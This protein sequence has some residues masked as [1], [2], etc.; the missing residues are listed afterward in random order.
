MVGV[1][2]SG[3]FALAEP[4]DL[5]VEDHSSGADLLLIYATGLVGFPP[6]GAVIASLAARIE[7]HGRSP[8]MVQIAVR[9]HNEQLLRHAANT[10]KCQQ[11]MT[12]VMQHS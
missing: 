6:V 11:R 5:R 1:L 3:S 12:Q 10:L 7:C 4:S 9:L 8:N 2:L